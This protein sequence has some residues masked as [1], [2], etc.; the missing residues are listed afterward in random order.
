VRNALSAEKIVGSPDMTLDIPS[1]S[2]A[3]KTID[4]GS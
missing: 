2:V 3:D 4:T 1:Q